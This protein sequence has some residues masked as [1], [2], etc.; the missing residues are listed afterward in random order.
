MIQDLTFTKNSDNNRWRSEFVSSG[1]K[2]AVQL[3]VKLDVTDKMSN[4]V[5]VYGNIEGMDRMTIANLGRTFTGEYLFEVDVPVGVTVTI[6]T[7]NEPVGGKITSE[8]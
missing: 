7:L 8:E 1:S 4:D 6:E 2:T 3:K 5:L